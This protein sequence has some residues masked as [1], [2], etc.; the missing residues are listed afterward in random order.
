[1]DTQTGI[2]LIIAAFSLTAL[3]L[4]IAEFCVSFVEHRRADRLAMLPARNR[5]RR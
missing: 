5:T 1:M 2:V 4:S 3:A